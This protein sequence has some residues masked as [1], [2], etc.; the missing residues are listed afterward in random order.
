MR[1][2]EILS[3]Q[4]LVFP[5]KLK[6]N[7]LQL[8]EWTLANSRTKAIPSYRLKLLMQVYFYCLT[9]VDTELIVI[10]A[11]EKSIVIQLTAY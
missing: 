5:L 10:P 9:C 1:A 2:F 3:L 7:A 4:I 6:N 8:Q 11:V